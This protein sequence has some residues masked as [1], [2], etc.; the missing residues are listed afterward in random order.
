MSESCSGSCESCH[1]NCSS[2]KENLHAAMNE[3]SNIKKVI[4][5]VSGKGGVGKSTLTS[6]LATAVRQ[7]GKSVG[8]L[9]A[10]IT[11]PSIPKAF[12]VTECS[13]QDEKGLYPALSAAGTSLN[14]G[15]KV[16]LHATNGME[17]TATTSNGVAEIIDMDGT[18]E[19][20]TVRVRF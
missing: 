18:A 5:V 9:D 8:I 7:Q 3:H 6:L 19:G 1:E 12:G 14:L 4:A 10:D 11:G 17:V 15:D 13:G 20:S 16:T 2:R